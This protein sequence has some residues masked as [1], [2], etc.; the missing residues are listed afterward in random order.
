MTTPKSV[1]RMSTP[2]QPRS[3]VVE[4][5]S[6]KKKTSVRAAYTMAKLAIMLQTDVRSAWNATHI[7]ISPRLS[8]H[9]PP[10]R[11][12]YYSVDSADSK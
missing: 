2:P 10:R 12:P 11:I 6:L 8:T 7:E 5:L 1:V 9:V 4:R 3:T